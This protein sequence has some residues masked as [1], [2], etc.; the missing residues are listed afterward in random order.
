MLF[1]EHQVTIVEALYYACEGMS[2]AEILELK[3]VADE[4]DANQ[5]TSD[6]NSSQEESTKESVGDSN[7]LRVCIILDFNLS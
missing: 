5:D 6:V 4:S 1:L 2:T 7:K 3:N